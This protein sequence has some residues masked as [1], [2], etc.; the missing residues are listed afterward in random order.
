MV[1]SS[2]VIPP[3]PPGQFC[4]GQ[5]PLD[6]EVNVR[7]VQGG[8]LRWP[9]HPGQGLEIRR[10]RARGEGDEAGDSGE[11]NKDVLLTRQRDPGYGG[12]KGGGLGQKRGHQGV[13]VPAPTRLD[14]EEL[15]SA[16]E[17]SYLAHLN[18]RGVSKNRIFCCIIVTFEEDDYVLW[19]YYEPI[20]LFTDMFPLNRHLPPSRGSQYS[21]PWFPQSTG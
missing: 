20:T 19:Y 14:E 9:Q 2:D 12:R 10:P 6:N 3:V 5:L 16:L 11:A 1:L 8:W 7:E 4:I 17:R 21:K 15:W 18:W 13:G